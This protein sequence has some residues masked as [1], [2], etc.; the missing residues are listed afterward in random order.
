MAWVL[1]ESQG[2]E[3]GKIKDRIATYLQG[4]GLDL[5]CGPWKISKNESFKD[6]CIGV[7]VFPGADVCEN[8]ADLDLFKDESFDYLFSSH[9]LEDFF[10]TEAALLKWW[11][12][13]RVDGGL[14]LYLPL[15]RLVAK[16]M[17]LENWADF[18]PNIGEHG[19]NPAHRQDLDPREVK[20]TMEHVGHAELEVYEIR[21]GG[22]EYSF[23]LIYKKLSSSALGLAKTVNVRTAPKAIVVRYGACGDMIQTGPV[24]RLL[25]EQ[26]YY[27]ILNMSNTSGS[28]EAIKNNPY[29]DE[30]AVQRRNQVNPANLQEYWEELATKC[31]RFVNLTGCV[32]DSLLIPDRNM[33]KA[34]AA[35]REKA[36]EASDLDLMHLV[37]QQYRKMVGPKNYYDAHLER[38]GLS[39]RGLNGELYFKLEEELPAIDFRQRHKDHFVILWSLAGSAYHKWYPWFH[40]VVDMVMVKIPEAVVVSVGEDAC[41]LMERPESAR[42]LPRA[43]KWKWRQ[44]LVM[45]KY[46]DL[47]IGAETGILNAAGCFP[48]PK[49]TLL[50]H[51][52]HDNLC[53]YWKNDYCL[54][55]EN[56]FCY[57]CHM[58]HYVHPV[59]VHCEQCGL[60]HKEHQ[61]DVLYQY[62]EGIWSCPTIGIHE[63]A[64]GTTPF[65]LCQAQGIPPERVF[66][67]IKEVYEVWKSKRLVEELATIP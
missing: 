47:V 25:K 7:D 31:D 37:I 4:R 24:L 50:S 14:I 40:K 49:I 43:G 53:K 62:G 2:N 22:Q 51:S 13:I 15:T 30:I 23:L 6:N 11:S 55:P 21:C 10:Y 35:L 56:T 58:L 66:N 45:T 27:V 44:S 28:L 8:I 39:E 52:T 42:C 3:S 1:E 17:G 34:A 36:P 20:R 38:A 60:T 63:D 18:Y 57:P 5:G 64:E 19:G 9:A 61:D 16:D 48:T 41:Q 54:A 12:K 67:R 59:G 32:E 46:A 65:P 33:Y 26:G 29:I